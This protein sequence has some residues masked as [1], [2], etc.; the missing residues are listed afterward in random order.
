MTDPFVLG[1]TY[2]AVENTDKAIEWFT[3]SVDEKSTSAI[4]LLITANLIGDAANDPR[5]HALIDRM[6]YPK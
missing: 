6:D 4:Y 3:R 2:A 1:D 5:F